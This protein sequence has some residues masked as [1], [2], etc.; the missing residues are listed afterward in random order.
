MGLGVR[1]S[2]GLRIGD[3]LE[4]GDGSAGKFLN[5]DKNNPGSGD[6]NNTDDGESDDFFG[7][8]DSFGVICV[9]YHF[10]SS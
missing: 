3:D 1:A 8:I 5:E 4:L 7:F 10:G 6:A 2:L 9:C